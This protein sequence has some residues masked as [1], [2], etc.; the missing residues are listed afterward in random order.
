MVL[1]NGM[2]A[3]EE[4]IMSTCIAFIRQQTRDTFLAAIH[5]PITMGD[6][7]Q[8]SQGGYDYWIVK[9]DSNGIKQ[10]DKR[11]GGSTYDKMKSICQTSDKGYL[12]GGW[13]CFRYP[14]ATRQR[15][16]KVKAISGL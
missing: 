4:Q 10:W 5:F 6:V 12:M 8:P 1:N 2:R 16:S 7:T 9:T 15:A 14:A 11:F 13:S 3:S